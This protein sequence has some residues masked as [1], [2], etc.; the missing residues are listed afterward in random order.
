MVVEA[1]AAFS[2]GQILL[3]ENVI[4]KDEKHFKAIQ[5]QV[6]TLTSAFS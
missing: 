5:S 2:D 4:N 3:D 6:Q 1:M